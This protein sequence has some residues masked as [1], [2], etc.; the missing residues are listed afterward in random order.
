MTAPATPIPSIKDVQASLAKL[1][2]ELLTQLASRSKVP[3]ST[4]TKIR[5]GVTKNPGI[6]TVRSFWSAL[7]KLQA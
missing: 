4:L 7:R 6:E 5:S 2:P 1:T 3:L